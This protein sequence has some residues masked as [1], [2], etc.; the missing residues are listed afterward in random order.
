MYLEVRITMPQN[1]PG[2]TTETIKGTTCIYCTF[3]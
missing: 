2:L 1:N 3:R